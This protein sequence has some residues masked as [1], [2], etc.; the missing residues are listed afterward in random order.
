MR[1]F[2]IS[3]NSINREDIENA[4]SGIRKTIEPY[5]HNKLHD[6]GCFGEEIVIDSIN[7]PSFSKSLYTKDNNGDKFF[8]PMN[9]LY[10]ETKMKTDFSSSY[11]SCVIAKQLKEGH[12]R[13]YNALDSEINSFGDIYVNSN[14]VLCIFKDTFRT[15]VLYRGREDSS[16]EYK[17]TVES[18]ECLEEDDLERL[19]ALNNTKKPMSLHEYLNNYRLFRDINR[20]SYIHICSNNKNG[21]I[22]EISIKYGKLE[23]YNIC[24]SSENFKLGMTI[25]DSDVIVDSTDG[26]SKKVDIENLPSSLQNAYHEGVQFLKKYGRKSANK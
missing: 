7:C 2:V 3:E 21:T 11:Y 20:C 12:Y 4:L 6:I 25:K 18:D 17:I 23:K 26:K 5:I 24:E 16:V 1:K 22:G 14:N 15:E 19:A 8:F 9:T 13:L 10:G